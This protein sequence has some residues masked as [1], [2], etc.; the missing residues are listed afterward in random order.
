M[1]PE[2]ARKIAR[3]HLGEQ[4]IHIYR[5]GPYAD[6]WTV[7]VATASVFN[8][9]GLV[10]AATPDEAARLAA[11]QLRAA[12]WSPS[13]ARLEWE[14]YIN[15]FRLVLRIEGVGTPLWWMMNH[16]GWFANTC[17]NVT[18]EDGDY[19]TMPLAEIVRIIA[20]WCATHLPSLH[21]PPFPGAAQ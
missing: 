20:K 4:L 7:Q 8:P 10:T 18:Q 1:T 19:D 9:T 2:E 14:P 13:H 17:D 15:G 6:Q 5:G 11:A 21:L 16:D 3:H 12:G